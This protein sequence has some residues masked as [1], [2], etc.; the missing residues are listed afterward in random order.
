MSSYNMSA[1]N[2]VSRS[3]V[4]S[5]ERNEGGRQPVYL[6][7]GHLHVGTQSY[8]AA[9]SCMLGSCVEVCLWDRKLKI[10]GAVHYMLPGDERSTAQNTGFKGIRDLTSAMVAAGADQSNI[11]AKVFGGSCMLPE[12]RSTHIGDRNVRAAYSCLKDLRIAII[13]ED[14]GGERGRKVTFFT[15]TGEVGV[16]LV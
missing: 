16:R 3:S 8:P 12:L 1:G 13:N 7:P 6:H 4:I 11:I 15:D 5:V 10:G 9:I 2:A 14:V